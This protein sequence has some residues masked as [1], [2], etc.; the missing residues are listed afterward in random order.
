MSALC[1]MRTPSTRRL[2]EWRWRVALLRLQLDCSHQ[3]SGGVSRAS[4][5]ITRERGGPAHSRLQPVHHPL[6]PPTPLLREGAAAT[7]VVALVACLSEWESPVVGLHFGVAKTFDGP[8]AM[9]LSLTSQ[10]PHPLLCAFIP[11]APCI[12]P[13]ALVSKIQSVA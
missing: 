9:V 6:P 5:E 7:G 1:S 2:H 8:S 3:G 13:H 12:V 4:S 10:Y 11:Q